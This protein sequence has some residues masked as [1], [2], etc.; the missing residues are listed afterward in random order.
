MNAIKLTSKIIDD[1]INWLAKVLGTIIIFP[2]IFA[3]VYDVIIRYFTNN[4]TVWAYD[5]T[6]MSYAAFFLLGAPYCLQKD[7]HVR[8]DTFYNRIPERGRALLECIFLLLFFFPLI[9]FVLKY[10]VPWAY[11]SWIMHERSQYTMWRPYVFPIKSILPI[12]FI[13]L[14]LQAISIFI[15]NVVYAIKGVKL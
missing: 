3:T 14:G 12:S 5:F 8:V 1:I 6:W 2:L 13:L 11:K 15:K 7:G 9:Y 4:S 10:S